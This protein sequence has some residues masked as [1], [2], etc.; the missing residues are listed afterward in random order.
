MVI[1]D[2]VAGGHC[3]HDDYLRIVE[4]ALAE[5]KSL[6]ARFKA[7]GRMDECKA[8]LGRVIIM[9]KEVAAAR[10]EGGETPAAQQ[11]VPSPFSPAV[12]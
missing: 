10:G 12:C 8:C 7:A 3:S 1:R 5:E 9:R 6:A 11:V 2:W 4:A